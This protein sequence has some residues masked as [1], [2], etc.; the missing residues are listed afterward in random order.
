MTLDNIKE[1]LKDFLAARWAQFQDTSLYLQLKDRYDSMSPEFQTLTKFGAG[2]TVLLLLILMPL[3]WYFN[4][5]DRLTD[6]EDQKVSLRELLKIRQELSQT[7]QVPPSLSASELKTQVS[8]ALQGMSLTPEQIQDVSEQTF[9]A[10]PSQ[11]EIPKSIIQNGIE[12]KLKKL[13]LKQIVDIG[14]KLQGISQGVKL[15]ALEVHAQKENPHYFDVVYRI[16]SF[17]V[18]QSAPTK[19]GNK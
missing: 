11:K 3:G 17:A 8:Q 14:Y 2:I 6:F 16:V 9:S 13:N 18:Q 10:D 19:T 12:A 1:Q 7:P 15:T 5:G 4:A